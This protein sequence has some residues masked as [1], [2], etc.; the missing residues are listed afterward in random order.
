MSLDFDMDTRYF[1]TQC[2]K[3]VALSTFFSFSLFF[4]SISIHLFLY[5]QRLGHYILV[6]YIEIIRKRKKK[7]FINDYGCSLVAMN[8]S[9]HKKNACESQREKKRKKD[10]KYSNHH[11]NHETPSSITRENFNS[12]FR[13]I[14]LS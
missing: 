10:E 9:A 2:K 1:L 12:A 7:E 14:S 11:N 8:R 13:T 3:A 5:F 6:F 4:S